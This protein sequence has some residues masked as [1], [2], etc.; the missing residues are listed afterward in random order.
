[1]KKW[2]ISGTAA[3]AVTVS[4]VLVTQVAAAE[5]ARPMAAYDQVLTDGVTAHVV[6][7]QERVAQ[8]AAR[9]AA[10]EEARRQAEEEARRQFEAQR[11]GIG[12]SAYTGSYY[13]AGSDGTRQCIVK[14]ESGGDYGVVSSNGLWHGA[15]QFT[16]GTADNA[17]RAMGRSDLVGV[18]P[19]TWSRADQ[20]QAFWTIWNHGAGRHN[21][22]TARGC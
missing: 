20:D 13:D 22:P 14:K 18:A 2:I 12:P 8:E 3:M 1:M 5:Q 15:Y 21:W 7:E 9:L 16:R 6:A 4:A 19:N 11:Y 17:A 10:E